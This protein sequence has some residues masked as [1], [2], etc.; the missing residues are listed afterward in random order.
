MN[1]AGQARIDHL[2]VAAPSLAEGAAW[3]EATLGIERGAVIEASLPTPQGL[4][5]PVCGPTSPPPMT[6]PWS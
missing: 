4:L 1:P 5:R 3:C 6:N 2:V